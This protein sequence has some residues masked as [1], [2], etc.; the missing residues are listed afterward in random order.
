M[1]PIQEVATSVG[2][3]I[4]AVVRRLSAGW[5]AS[6]VGLWVAFVV[7]ALIGWRLE[8]YWLALSTGVLAVFF[9]FA[10]GSAILDEATR[11]RPRPLVERVD[12]AA[13]ALRAAAELVDELSAEIGSR[14]TAA[15]RLRDDL[16]RYEHLIE[17]RSEE[18]RAVGEAISHAFR[19][20]ARRSLP[21]R[22]VVSA[23]NLVVGAIL[24]GAVS[25]IFFN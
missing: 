18:A 20:E 3:E 16:E 19:E 23:V 15:E 17:I 22:V 9:P 25:A 14:T 10:L 24:G 5:I 4:L 11:P 21:G 8:W 1:L 2:H 7:T 13:T 6:F 12:E